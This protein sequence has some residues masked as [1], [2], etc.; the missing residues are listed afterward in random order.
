MVLSTVLVENLVDHMDI[1]E[2][3]VVQLD[4]ERRILF[5]QV[6]TVIR[7]KFVSV[8]GIQVGLDTV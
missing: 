7:G 2:V 4:I 5:L 1:P 3:A 6:G 8:L